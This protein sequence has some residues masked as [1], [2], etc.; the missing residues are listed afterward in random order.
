M[1]PGERKSKKVYSGF[2]LFPNSTVVD[3]ST[4]I[5]K[6]KGLHIV[7]GT[8]REREGDRQREKKNIAKKVDLG[9]INVHLQHSGRSH[10]SYI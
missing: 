5:F 3:Y 2:G 6:S 4:L 9:L 8:E 1:A 10:N 7:N